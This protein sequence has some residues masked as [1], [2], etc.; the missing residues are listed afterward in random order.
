V[1]PDRP[2]AEG[3]LLEGMLE[4]VR[5]PKGLTRAPRGVDELAT[6]HL[7]VNMGPQ[8][9]STHGVL[10]VL[11]ELDGEE[12]IAAEASL[13]YLHR[14]VEKL[15]EHRRYAAVGTLLDRSDYVSGVHTELAFAMGVEELMGIEVPRKAPSPA[16]A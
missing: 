6:E 9:P 1:T 10:H 5:L 11:L 16:R 15:A 3:V 7:V 12:V 2:R 8:H 14:G 4:P 13:G